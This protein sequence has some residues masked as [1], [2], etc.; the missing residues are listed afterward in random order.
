ME[1]VAMLI[2][3]AV[4]TPGPLLALLLW[5]L[6]GLTAPQTLLEAGA[7]NR[8]LA[9]S[10]DPG[11][12]ISWTAENF[13]GESAWNTGTYGIGYETGSG[14]QNLFQSTV[15][16]G[17]RSIYTRASFNL[18]DPGAIS[19]MFL[20]VDHD[21]GYVAWINGT[22]VSRSASMPAGTP[23]WNTTPAS[24]ESSNGASPVYTPL[25]DIT[26]AALPVLHPGDNVL[27]IAAYNL[28]ESS[29]DLVLVPQLSIDATV[30]RGPYLQQ[31]THDSVV[32]RWRT[33]LATDSRVRFGNAPGNLTR[34]VDDA[35]VT[36]EH[37]VT[38]TGLAAD[39]TYYYSVGS[40]TG[41]LAGDDPEHFFLTSPPVGTARPTRVWVLGDSGT[42]NADARAVADAYE[43]Y[44]GTTHTDLWLMLGDNAYNDGTDS[45]YQAAV[46]D[47]YPGMLRK[48]VLWPTLG[49][50]DGYTA[51]SAT[52]TGP[53]YDI[54][55]LPTN[56][57]AGGQASGTEAYYSFDYGN[58]HFICLESYETD[59]SPGGAMMRWLEQ[60]VADTTQEWII[61]FWHHPP[62]SKGSHDSDTEVPLRQMRQNALPILEAAGVD[63][64]LSGHSHSYERSYLIDSHY[65]ISTTLT[66]DMQVDAGDGRTDGDGAYKAVYNEADPYAGAVYITAGSSGKTS[67]GTL[68]HPVMV[69]ASLKRLGSLVLD[70]DGNRLD[71][72]FLREN[73]AID[74]HF[75]ILK[76]PDNCPAIANPDQ[77]DA[78]GDSIGD[79]CDTDDDNDGLTDIFELSIGTNPLL[80]DSDSD[81]LSDFQEVN[82]DDDPAYTPGV[83]LNPLLADTD[84]DELSDA[85]DPIPLDF[86]FGDGDVVTDGVINA[87]DYIVMV[88]LVLGLL[89]PDNTDLAHADLYPADYPDG[90]INIQDLLVF[91]QLPLP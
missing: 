67:N 41:V 7:D 78:D 28:S 53:Y 29:S 11:I 59:R 91:Q 71:A 44:T 90:I 20:G 54:F 56:G 72:K 50:H 18:A 73:G 55:T 3:R 19:A 52:Q 74:D 47:M 88:R 16:S 25:Q 32:V 4:A 82:Y 31:G 17:T 69:H 60:D 68:D 49:N 39:T 62:Y 80:A 30:T 70:I 27:A 75:T 8:Y 12:G 1:S 45:Q 48:S 63:L 5:F 40:T 89:Q 79:A 13:P 2:S 77:A 33:A 85:V 14:A 24:H 37:E 46:F 38:L 15:P 76:N 86:N 21:D 65:G 10:S 23:L 51:D 87:G 58:I 66:A 42:A 22:E 6:P 57:E 81:T 36:T 34:S 26:S 64:V 9:N 43:N 83:D 84:G 35:A 61:A